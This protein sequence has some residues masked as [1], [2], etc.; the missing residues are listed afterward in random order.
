M[1]CGTDIATRKGI[2]TEPPGNVAVLNWPPIAELETEVKTC[3][4]ELAAE[5]PAW[6]NP[7]TNLALYGKPVEALAN[8][9]PT[10]VEEVRI[11][12]PK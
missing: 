3:E 5:L 7:E 10:A 9:P 12:T 8:G 2:A 1:V 6:L 4:T 11:P